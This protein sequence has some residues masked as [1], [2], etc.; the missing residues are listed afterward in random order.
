VVP[1]PY[2]ASTQNFFN[3]SFDEIMLRDTPGKILSIGV[4]KKSPT[5]VMDLFSVI[6]TDEEDHVFTDKED[7]FVIKSPK[8]VASSPVYQ[9]IFL[10]S[11][12][13]EI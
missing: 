13:F 7:S 12:R 3:D 11:R 4:L 5:G 8:R 6:D 9:P 2:R 1:S 10:T